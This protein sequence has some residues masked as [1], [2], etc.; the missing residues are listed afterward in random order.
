MR[1]RASRLPD[2]PVLEPV[3]LAR[4]PTAMRKNLRRGRF[5]PTGCG[6]EDDRDQ[7]CQPH[8][9]PARHGARLRAGRGRRV[10]ALQRSLPPSLW[11]NGLFGLDA[12]VARSRRGPTSPKPRVLPCFD[13]LAAAVGN[14]MSDVLRTAAGKVGGGRDDRG[15]SNRVSLHS[16]LRARNCSPPNRAPRSLELRQ[17][18]VA[19]RGARSACRAGR[20]SVRFRRRRRAGKARAGNRD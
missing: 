19:S 11:P 3:L 12:P 1:S 9:Q 4:F 2:D 20:Q 15:S 10:W 18:F 17:S 5:A 8:G 14:L 16:R 7:P 13:R 6:R